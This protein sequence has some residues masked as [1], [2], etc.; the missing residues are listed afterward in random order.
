MIN[1]DSLGNA[2]K[3]EPID[4]WLA[5]FCVSLDTGRCGVLEA[6]A[7]SGT[8]LSAAISPEGVSDIAYLQPVCAAAI[9][10]TAPVQ[11]LLPRADAGGASHAVVVANPIT[12][13]WD[14]H[15]WH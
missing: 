10:Q 11:L 12:E 9:K 13:I 7:D 5:S 1:P 15:E 4:T 3:A 6:A 8:L 14:S 2:D